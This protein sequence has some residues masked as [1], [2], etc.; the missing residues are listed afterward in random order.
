ML[1]NK[2]DYRFGSPKRLDAVILELENGSTTH[3]SVKRVIGLPG[4]TVKIENGK[5]YINNKELKGFS[6]EEIL[7]AGLAAYDVA[8]EDDEYF[9]MGD[10]RNNSNDA[11][12]WETHYVSRDEVLGK[13]W[14]RYYPSIKV[15]K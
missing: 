15:I 6:E 11:R 14:F 1:V 8:L 4:E 13:A 12:E 2:L 9:V 5:I 3:Y 10:N 7:S